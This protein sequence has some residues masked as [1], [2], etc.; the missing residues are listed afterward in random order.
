MASH[1][2]AAPRNVVVLFRKELGARPFPLAAARILKYFKQKSRH[3][4]E[5]MTHFSERERDIY[6]WKRRQS[7]RD[8]QLKEHI[9]EKFGA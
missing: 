5:S 4:G 3:K 9:Q 6:E 2:R 8:H 1:A 7:T